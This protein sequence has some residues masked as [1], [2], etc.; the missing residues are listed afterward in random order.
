MAR[1]RKKPASASR[2][3]VSDYR[4]KAKRKNNPPAKIAAEGTVPVMPKIEYS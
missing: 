1:Q 4:H 2:A 3:K